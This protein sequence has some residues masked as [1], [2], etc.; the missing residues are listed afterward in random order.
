MIKLYKQIGETPLEA[1]K[2]LRRQRPELSEM[3]LSYAGRLDPMAAGILPVLV[4]EEN[5]RREEFLNR[6][7][8]YFFTV[9]FGVQTD[10]FDLLGVPEL[11]TDFMQASQKTDRFAVNNKDFSLTKSKL[12]EVCEQLKGANTMQ[13]PPYSS[14]TVMLDGTKTP[15]WKVARAGRLDEVVIPEK[16]TQIYDLSVRETKWLEKNYIIYYIINQIEKV[17]GDFRQDEITNKWEKVLGGI[18]DQSKL[19]TAKFRVRC[20]S[21]T[22][23]R[24]L[25]DRL[26]VQIGIHTT[27]FSLLR[28]DVGV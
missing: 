8:T 2:R 17:D 1:L 3:R 16:T 18:D 12:T 23:I 22:Y 14:K 7:K 5:D 25:V 9:L 10:T 21:G 20:S 24:R 15:L 26:G 6:D 11:D 28:T 27:L 19:P 4:G 13:Y